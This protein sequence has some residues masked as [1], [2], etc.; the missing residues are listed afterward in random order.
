VIAQM[1]AALKPGGHCIVSVPQHMFHWSEQDR[2]ARHFRR[3]E[4]G[5]LRRKLEAAGLQIESK[6]SFVTLLLPAL[7]L[8]RRWSRARNTGAGSGELRLPEILNRP[9]EW[10]LDVERWLI[11]HGMRLPAGGSQLIVA[12][13]LPAVSPSWTGGSYEP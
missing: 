3:Y 7:Y 4:T 5:E 11:D 13:R 9:F 8:S 6:T 1:A 2:Q 12:R 10:T